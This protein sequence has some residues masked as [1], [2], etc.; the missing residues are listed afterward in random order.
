MGITRYR[1]GDVTITLSGDLEGFVRRA[2]DAALGGALA[3][4]EAEADEVAA[5]AREQWYRQVTL[6]TG[7]SGQIA[8]ITVISDDY[9]RVSVGSTDTRPAKGGKSAA[10]F[11]RRPGPLSQVERK[12]TDAEYNARRSAG[13]APPDAF[14]I[15]QDNPKAADGA[16]L[17]SE[18]V[19][20]PM[21]ARK[22]KLAKAIG[23]AIVARIREQ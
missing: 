8:R 16:Y 4:I 7:K 11:V 9:V 5:T 13:M 12:A 2:A 15:K 21:K 20:K 3:V 6:R 18:L 1:D 19:K 22:T 23:A 17:L 14:W 10:L